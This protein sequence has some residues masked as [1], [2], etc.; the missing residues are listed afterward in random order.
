MQLGRAHQ[1]IAHWK[2]TLEIEP[3][4]AQ[5]QRNLAWIFATCPEPAL[6]DGARAVELAEHALA[7]ERD[8]T[9]LLLRTLAAAHAE[10]GEFARAIAVG[11][12]A[13][14]AAEANGNAALAAELSTD[15]EQYHLNRPLRDAAPASVHPVN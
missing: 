11:S 12:E 15:I 3:N 13:L 14:Q 1:A 10:A 2:R 6:R 8:K 5:A 7:I 9:P 4:D